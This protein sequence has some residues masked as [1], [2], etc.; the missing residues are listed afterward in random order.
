MTELSESEFERIVT[1]LGDLERRSDH[2]KRGES[3][4]TAKELLSVLPEK[5]TW[6]A[7]ELDAALVKRFLD[8]PKC[9]IRPAF[10][11]HENTCERLWGHVKNVKE[12][13]GRD[14]LRETLDRP[15]LDLEPGHLGTAGP[16]VFLSH[17]LKDHHFAGRVRL[18]L[19]RNGVR[20]W[21]A[22]GDLHEGDNLFE[23]V[24]AALYRCEALVA[25]VSSLSVSSAWL[26]SEVGCAMREGKQIIALI[27]ASDVELCRFIEA[28]W[29]QNGEF[30]KCGQREE[31][32]TGEGI[33]L[34]SAVLERYMR[35]G[36]PSRILKF[37]TGMKK[38]LDSLTLA[39]TTAFYP[40]SRTGWPY[41]TAV[42]SF[43][44]VVALLHQIHGVQDGGQLA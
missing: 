10:Y 7:K 29:T 31:W 36:A 15:S 39:G 38:T 4:R 2:S 22:E 11:P 25:L 44:E 43:D 14:K 40:S 33:R 21:L 18:S 9:D 19:L 23:A 26:F 41:P 35:V 17:A 27:D 1:K 32:L 34:T 5:A 13:P 3:W 6:N 12:G 16:L 37:S 20:C 28:W 30:D 8:D 42:K 24:E